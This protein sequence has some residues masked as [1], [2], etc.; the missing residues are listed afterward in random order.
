MSTVSGMSE[1]PAQ[2]DG[3]DLHLA[4]GTVSGYK[5]VKFLKNNKTRPYSVQFTHAGATPCLSRRR[6][7]S[8]HLYLRGD[9]AALR[10]LRPRRR[11]VSRSSLF[12]SHALRAP[13]SR[14]DASEK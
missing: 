3:W 4:P 14:D 1:V 7:A 8:R 6:E 11:R 10:V 9:M 5:N 13:R 12:Q 2:H